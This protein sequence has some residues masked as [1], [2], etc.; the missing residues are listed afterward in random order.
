MAFEIGRREDQFD[1]DDVRLVPQT[2][3]V[4]SRS[5]IDVSTLF[6]S[7]HV[8]IPVVPA[9]MSTV[10]DEKTCVWLAKRGYFYIMH[11]FD[12]NPL[13]FIK[14]MHKQG[15]F[16][17]ISLGIKDADYQI[18]QKFRETDVAP[19]FITV[20]VAHGDSDEVQRMVKTIRSLFP[21]VFI[22]AG[23][24]ATARGAI[25]LAEAGAHAVKVGV[26][27]GLACL[28][29]PNTGF[30]TQGWQLSAIDRI[31]HAL[32]SRFPNVK[33]I[34]DGGI[35]HFGDIAKSIAFGADLVMIGGMLSGHD[36]N[37]GD[38]IEQD[39]QKFK[40]FFG[41]ASEYQKGA[42]THVEGRRLLMPYKGSLADTLKE[43][44]EHLQSSV[45]YAG[46][47]K[48]DDLRNVGYVRID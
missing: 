24:V 19:E 40:E 28:T 36:E 29:A 6:G 18:L 46:G 43:I 10:V 1:Y 25:E 44:E 39:G 3:V 4:K 22:I 37:P 8:K 9:N 21:S 41:S 33:I 15:L 32:D 38:I 16:A 2:C 42:K 13:P 31:S 48:L 11:R 14:S 20:D 5:E 27:P 30:G 45:S 12:F 7:A 26:G 47:R 17:S 35:R 23:N 34:A